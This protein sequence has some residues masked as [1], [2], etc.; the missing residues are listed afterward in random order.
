METG[1]KVL[2]V[3][4]EEP[5]MVNKDI[6]LQECALKMEEFNVGA[7]L[8]EE[9]NNYYIATEQDLAR[10]GVGQGMNPETTLIKEVMTK[11]MHTINPDDDVF[12]ALVKMRDFNIRHLPVV[13]DGKMIGLLTS[14]DILKIQP[15]LFEILAEK[16][17]LRE[18]ER[19]LQELGEKLDDLE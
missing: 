1:Y 8:I 18:E 3:M 6:S 2:D 5:V 11:M 9:N 12:D 15:Q 17:E 16:I 13:K 7:V 14:K 10:K 4:T 19:K